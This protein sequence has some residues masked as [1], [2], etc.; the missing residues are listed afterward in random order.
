M[1]FRNWDGLETEKRRSNEG[2][3]SFCPLCFGVLF[4]ISTKGEK[5]LAKIIVK[6]EFSN[7]S[8]IFLDVGRRDG[9]GSRSGQIDLKAET[10]SVLSFR[11]SD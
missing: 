1:K 3:T 4:S 7:K 10:N 9:K 2:L 6:W 11:V 5:S 8:E